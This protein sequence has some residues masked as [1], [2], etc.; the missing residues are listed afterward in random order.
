MHCIK[1]AVTLLRDRHWLHTTE[2][3][4]LAW[5]VDQGIARR[6]EWGY[7]LA[8]PRAHPGLLANHYSQRNVTINGQHRTRHTA[9]IRITD[10]GIAWLAETMVES[11]AA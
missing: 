9:A 8:N 2:H 5:L 3:Q 10:E 7:Q 11:A 1:N 6:T 4:L